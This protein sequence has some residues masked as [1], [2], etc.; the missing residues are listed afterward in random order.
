MTPVCCL[1]SAFSPALPAPALG[2]AAA[3]RA[4][5]PLGAAPQHHHH[6]L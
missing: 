4:T 1:T 5:P 2:L 6:H 3:W